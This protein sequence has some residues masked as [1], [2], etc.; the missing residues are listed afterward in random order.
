MAESRIRILNLEERVDEIYDFFTI[1]KYEN[2]LSKGEENDD[3]DN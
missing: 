3:P 1:M 2:E